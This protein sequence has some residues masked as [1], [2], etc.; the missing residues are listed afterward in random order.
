MDFLSTALF[1]TTCALIYKYKKNLLGAI[2]GLLVSIASM[3]SFM[4]LF[5]LFIVPLYTPSYTT[6]TVAAMIPTLFLPFNLTKAFMNSA[7]VLI[8]YKPVSTA[9]KAARVLPSNSLSMNR[10]AEENK[11]ESKKRFIMSLL[12][13]IGGILLAIICLLI[14][15]Y[16]LNGKFV[17]F[18]Q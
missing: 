3:T 9:L 18:S 10:S 14:F 5:N 13:T 11:A 15:F 4:L 6:A 17:A 2:L 16:K 1:S 7:I 8:L 12:I